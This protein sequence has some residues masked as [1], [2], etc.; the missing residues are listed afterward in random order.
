MMGLNDVTANQRK[1]YS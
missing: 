1:K